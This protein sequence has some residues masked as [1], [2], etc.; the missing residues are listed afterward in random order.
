MTHDY[1]AQQAE[2]FESFEA[3][4]HDAPEIATITYQF[5]PEDVDANWDGV[6]KALQAKGFRTARDD[7]DELLDAL[8]G[9]VAISAATIWKYEKL[10]TEIALQ[11]EFTPDGWGLLE[12]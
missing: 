6:Q 5:Y 2:T 12:D 7:G 8:I 4:A 11:F 10:A 3:F 9:P 1:K